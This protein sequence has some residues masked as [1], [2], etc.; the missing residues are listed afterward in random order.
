LYYQPQVNLFTGKIVGA[1]SLIRWQH[2]QMGLISPSKFIPIAEETGL[3]NDIG[4]WVVNS[5]CSQGKKWHDLGYNNLRI[6][7]NLSS[8][9]F[10]NP[11]LVAKIKYAVDNTGF[12][13]NFLDL[14]L[15]ESGIMKDVQQNIKMMTEI[16]AIGARISIDDFGTGYSSLSYLKSF[17]IDIL[18][19]DQS[20]I[21]NST[22]DPSDAIITSTIINM[23]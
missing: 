16:K 15:T 1:E 2:P 21:K 17:P 14:E 11:S 10:R 12:N 20:F 7:A 6:S 19:V 3:I 18:K 5:A 23:A 9:Q 4:N 13:P 8:V 22:I